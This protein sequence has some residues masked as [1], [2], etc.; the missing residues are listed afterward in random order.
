MSS[1]DVP[2]AALASSTSLV[3]G[4]IAD[5]LKAEDKKA[6]LTLRKTFQSVAWAIKAAACTFF[7]NR[8][9]LLWL[10]QLQGRISPQDVRL[11]QDVNKLLAATQF[12][13]DA[14]LNAVKYASRALS[15]SITSRRLLWLRN[16]QADAISLFRKFVVWSNIGSHTG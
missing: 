4:N 16:W 9:T 1:I 5:N 10:R 7:F 14:I 11:Q 12:S 8:I 2:V 6:E 13:A 3:T 15:S